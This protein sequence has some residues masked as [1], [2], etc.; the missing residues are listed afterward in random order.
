MRVVWYSLSEAFV[1]FGHN[2]IRQTHRSGITINSL[3][4]TFYNNSN[5]LTAQTPRAPLFFN[6]IRGNTDTGRN[7][8]ALTSPDCG[9]IRWCTPLPY[10]VANS[11]SISINNRL[12]PDSRLSRFV[13]QYPRRYQRH[14]TTP[15]GVGGLHSTSPDPS[16]RGQLLIIWTNHIGI[17]MS[18][19]SFCLVSHP[20]AVCLHIGGQSLGSRPGV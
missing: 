9:I 8:N 3:S 2:Y 11:L 14:K 18:N 5:Q 6:I 20:F 15:S 16:N 1:R 12:Y 4:P 17:E 7:T 19:P 10:T 13:T